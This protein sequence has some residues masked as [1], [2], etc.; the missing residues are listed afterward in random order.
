L[1]NIIRITYYIIFIFLFFS[2]A[3]GYNFNYNILKYDNKEVLLLINLCGNNVSLYL[4][5]K[6]FHAYGCN[7]YYVLLPFKDYYLYKIKEDLGDYYLLGNGIIDVPDN[8]FTFSFN[9]NNSVL[10]VNCS[11]CFIETNYK[12]LFCENNCS[13]PVEMFNN[14]LYLRIK[15]GNNSLFKVIKCIKIKDNLSDAVINDT[16]FNV[17]ENLTLNNVSVLI[18]GYNLS[19]KDRVLIWILISIIVIFIFMNYFKIGRK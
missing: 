19:L 9:C 12:Y 17:S 2:V 16:L 6:T 10:S 1:N 18:E 4:D 3:F 5:N 14:T 13:V 8:F 7:T 15:Q 11:K